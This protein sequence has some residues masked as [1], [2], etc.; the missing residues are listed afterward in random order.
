MKVLTFVLKFLMRFLGVVRQRR[1]V[2]VGMH[3]SVC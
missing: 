3:E 1:A 2:H